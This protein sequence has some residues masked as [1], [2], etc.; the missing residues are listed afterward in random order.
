MIGRNVVSAAFDLDFRRPRHSARRPATEFAPPT[1]TPN[2][3]RCTAT[4]LAR[5][6][7]PPRARRLRQ[8]A[9]TATDF[10]HRRGRDDLR[11]FRR[12]CRVRPVWSGRRIGRGHHRFRRH[13]RSRRR[14]C[15]RGRGGRQ[16]ERFERG[17]CGRAGHGSLLAGRSLPARRLVGGLRGVRPSSRTGDAP[18]RAAGRCGRSH[19]ARRPCRLGARQRVG[20]GLRRGG[21]FC[22]AIAPV[23]E[24]SPC[25]STVTREYSRSRS[26]LSV[27]TADASRRVS[28]WLSLAT[29]WICCDWRA[30][31]A[32]AICSRR[33]AI[34]D[35]LANTASDDGADRAD[36]PRS[37]PPQRAA[38][39][40]ILFGQKAGQHAAGIFGLEGAGQWSEFFAIRPFRPS[41]SPPES[42]G[43]H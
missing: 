11:R 31:S 28:F 19:S 35:W 16:A 30:R 27:S 41:S 42:R 2:S 7:A 8:P 25:S 17:G 23:T 12:F 5:R 40:I 37:Q 3:V 22:R 38:I 26:P 6:L 43:K 32:A 14:G 24:S 34:E 29:D 1:S 39:E 33:N 15:R 18:A 4:L 36:A 20:G 21:A 10:R 13:Q 9:P